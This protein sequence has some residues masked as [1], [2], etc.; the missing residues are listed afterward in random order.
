MG[1][2]LT[3]FKGFTPKQFDDL[4]EMHVQEGYPIDEKGTEVESQKSVLTQVATETEEH[5]RAMHKAAGWYANGVDS[6]PEFKVSLY[7]WEY[8]S[9]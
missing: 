2:E 1:I 8:K 4:I 6:L 3:C 9:K 7:E 5:V